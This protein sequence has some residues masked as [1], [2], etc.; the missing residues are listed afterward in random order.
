MELKAKNK[1]MFKKSYDCAE[2]AF[3]V[4]EGFIAITALASFIQ[5][6]FKEAMS[7]FAICLVTAVLLTMPFI[8]ER[9]FGVVMPPMLKL[10]LMLLIVGGPV[11]GKIYKFYYKVPFWD[12]LL[13]TGSG[14]LFAAL[15][16]MIPALLDPGNKEH[17][18]C[19]TLASAFCFTL[20]VAV[21]WEF[22]EYAMDNFFNMDMQQDAIVSNINSYLLGPEKGEIASL[23]GIESVT[24][25]GEAVAID[26]YL[27]IGLIDTMRDMLVCGIGGVF[28]CVSTVLF[29]RGVK[30]FNWLKGMLPRVCT[31]E[32]MPYENAYAA[33]T[34][35]IDNL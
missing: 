33:C 28:Y 3:F 8:V 12:K 4:G 13:H 26:G 31:T 35:A 22:Y 27:D 9:K 34:E 19:L 18:L 10:S 16:A 14:F 30:A 17:S 29:K 32:A 6:P 20:A 5:N 7:E 21:L 11:L 25:N 23:S 15:G 2:T 24:V 1:N